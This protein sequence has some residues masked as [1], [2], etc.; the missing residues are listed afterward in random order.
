MKR[1]LLAA[2]LSA[3]AS[4]VFVA[5]ASA[6]AAFPQLWTNSSKTELLRSVTVLPKNQPDAL[7]FELTQG[8]MV[9]PSGEKHP[10][11]LCNEVELGTTVLVNSGEAETKLATPFGVAEGDTCTIDEPAGPLTVPTYF[12]TGTS[13]AVIGNITILGGAGPPFH[14]VVHSMKLSINRAGTFCTVALNGA[15]AGVENAVEGFVEESPPNL[16]LNFAGV[17]VTTTCGAVKEKGPF[18]AHFFLDTMSTTTDTAF[19]AN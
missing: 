15:A 1:C 12:D 13:G 16:T 8:P 5:S 11:V 3:F 17:P 14:A 10:P 7:E 19:V 4:C 2:A 9:F 18:V 6:S